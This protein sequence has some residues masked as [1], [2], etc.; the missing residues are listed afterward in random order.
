M[1]S[2]FGLLQ[3]G[4]QITP[5]EMA[6]TFNCGIGMAVIV[7]PSEVQA[8]SD[9]LE[10]ALEEVEEIGS[11]EEGS[12]GCTVQGAAHTWNSDKDWVATHNV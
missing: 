11:I 9:A 8:V 3:A 12:R 10:G 7:D 4:G 1:P 2:I 6:R 5:E